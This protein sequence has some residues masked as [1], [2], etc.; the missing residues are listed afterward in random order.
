[1]KKKLFYIINIIVFISCNSPKN[2]SFEQKECLNCKVKIF[3]SLDNVLNSSVVLQKKI[4]IINP[5]WKY[6]EV[7]INYY[8]DKELFSSIDTYPLYFDEQIQKN[9]TFEHKKGLH[10]IGLNPKETKG[11]YYNLW[12]RNIN[13]EMLK[14]Y[15]PLGKYLVIEDNLMKK[16]YEDKNSL[17]YEEPFSEFKRKNPELLEFLTKGDSIELEVISPVKQKYKFKA[18]W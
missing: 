13:S 14:H 3:I 1:M 11:I 5:N 9:R 2:I 16:T 7:K 4:I 12:E 8:K 6:S 15:I 18:E 17:I 10:I